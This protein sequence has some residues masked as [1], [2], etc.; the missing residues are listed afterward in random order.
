[1][2]KHMNRVMGIQVHEIKYHS[3]PT[4]KAG[5]MSAD[6]MSNSLAIRASSAFFR[7]PAPMNI[8]IWY[9][10][11]DLSPSTGLTSMPL[12]TAVVLVKTLDT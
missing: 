12:K 10:T 3:W 9:S 5:S 6:V 2:F 11:S 4:T 8:L 1:V 7:R